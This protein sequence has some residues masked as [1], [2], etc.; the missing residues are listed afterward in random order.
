VNDIVAQTTTLVIKKLNLPTI[1]CHAKLLSPQLVINKKFNPYS[2]R[3]LADRSV[4]LKRYK[5]TLK[6]GEINDG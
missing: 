1:R 2:V 3:F 6:T 5:L 4:L